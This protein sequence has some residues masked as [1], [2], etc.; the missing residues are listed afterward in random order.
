MA[1]TRQ[2]ELTNPAAIFNNHLFRT[3]LNHQFTRAFSVRAI[4]DYNATL[5][6]AALVNLERSKRLT[7]DLLLTYFVHPG[8][9]IYVG[10][11]DH[12]ENLSFD[13]DNPAGLRRTGSPGFPTGRQFFAK[14]SYLVRF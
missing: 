9:A 5:P 8:T 11:T 1:H 6:N 12:R 10:Y 7:G 3:K 4:V 13:P 14:V 2:T